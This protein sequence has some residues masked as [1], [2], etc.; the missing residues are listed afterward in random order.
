MRTGLLMR[1]LLCTNF[2]AVA[3]GG[4]TDSFIENT[5]W[6]R[7]Q[8]LYYKIVEAHMKAA[9]VLCRGIGFY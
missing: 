1:I 8:F 9:L 3:S 4:D 6:Q 5:N 7:P 2:F